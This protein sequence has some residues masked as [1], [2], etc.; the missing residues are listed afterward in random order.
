MD[1]EVNI[2]FKDNSNLYPKTE[3][4]EKGFYRVNAIGKSTKFSL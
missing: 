2:C 3:E 4:A 1:E